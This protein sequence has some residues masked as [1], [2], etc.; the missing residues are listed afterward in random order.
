MDRNILLFLALFVGIVVLVGAFVVLMRKRTKTVEERL[1]EW[2]AVDR[3]WRYYEEDVVGLSS[4]ISHLADFGRA[5]KALRSIAAGEDDQGNRVFFFNH[6]DIAQGSSATGYTIP[7]W[8]VCLIESREAFGLD[9]MIIARVV[10]FLEGMLKRLK[11]FSSDL[12]EIPVAEE[13]FKGFILMA[14]DETICRQ[15]IHNGMI[16]KFVRYVGLVPLAL[17]VQIRGNMLAVYTDQ[18]NRTLH[19]AKDFETLHRIAR[20]LYESVRGSVRGRV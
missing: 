1:F 6:D 3:G 7:S 13:S 9:L 11:P 16:E 12:K 18:P 15:V 8:S 10:K 5:R 19:K 2:L 14:N 20:G 4:R 17:S